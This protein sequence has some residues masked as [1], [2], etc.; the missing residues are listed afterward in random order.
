MSESLRLLYSNVLFILLV[1]VIH[2]YHVKIFKLTC[3]QARISISKYFHQYAQIEQLLTCLITLTWKVWYNDLGLAQMPLL[4]S[5]LSFL[6]DITMPTLFS[7]LQIYVLILVLIF[8]WSSLA[9]ASWQQILCLAYLW[10]WSTNTRP[11]VW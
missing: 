1:C 9:W 7:F 2:I 6:C 10:I 3:K 11:R 5:C 8:F 4:P